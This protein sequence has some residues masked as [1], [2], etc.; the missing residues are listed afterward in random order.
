MSCRVIRNRYVMD[1]ANCKIFIPESQEYI[2]LNPSSWPDD[3]SCRRWIR[4][5]PQRRRAQHD[6]RSG[7]SRDGYGVSDEWS[8]EHKDRNWSGDR[9]QEEH[10][11]MW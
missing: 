3:V 4:D 11:K 10:N 6:E 1:V 5:P 9:Y 8:D 7:Y 2:A